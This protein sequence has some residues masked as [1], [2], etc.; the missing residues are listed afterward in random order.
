MHVNGFS[1]T[2]ISTVLQNRCYMCIHT[3]SHAYH[4]TT[5]IRIIFTLVV[6]YHGI[7]ILENNKYV[8]DDLEQKVGSDRTW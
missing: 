8:G 3:H 1:S 2:C 6:T 4:T 5:P 7:F